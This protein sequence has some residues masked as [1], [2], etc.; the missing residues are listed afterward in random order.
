MAIEKLTIDGF[1]GLDHV[2]IDGLTRV[3]LFVG[4]NNAGKTSVLEAVYLLEEP[5]SSDSIRVLFRRRNYEPHSM[6]AAAGFELL[7]THGREPALRIAANE[8]HGPATW[9]TLG[10]AADGSG[11]LLGWGRGGESDKA[12]IQG[13]FGGGYLAERDARPPATWFQLPD[14]SETKLAERTSDLS[15]QK[16][17]AWLI[18]SLQGIDPRVVDVR[19]LKVNEYYQP[20]IDLGGAKMVPLSHCGHGMRYAFALFTELDRLRNAIV[21]IDEFE[22]GLHFS[23]QVSV[24]RAIRQVA[25][26]N[27]LQLFVTTHSDDCLEASHAAY[28]GAEADLAVYRLDRNDTGI[29]VV[30]YDAETRDHAFRHRWEVR[31]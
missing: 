5:F 25:Q 19:P 30:R 2:E 31:G 10:L 23:A 1:R 8:G 28:A 27:D 21:L 26:A 11:L 29:R 18:E 17:T 24:W 16:R 4:V 14:L 6:T 22:V 3:N 13:A 12:K 20:F 15:A 7:A 9:M